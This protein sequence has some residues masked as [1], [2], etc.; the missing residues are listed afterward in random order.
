MMGGLVSIGDIVF[1]DAKGLPRSTIS[2]YAIKT[3]N[4]RP[5]SKGG[6]ATQPA[7]PIA[8]AQAQRGCLDR[9]WNPLRISNARFELSV[10]RN[11][12][13]A[14]SLAFKGSGDPSLSKGQY[15]FEWMGGKKRSH[16]RV[17][18]RSE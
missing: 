9:A 8:A 16:R 11:D 14:A 10:L 2:C 5:W 3:D 13:A 1:K 6:G 17:V 4:R 7:V 15:F 18:T 12:A